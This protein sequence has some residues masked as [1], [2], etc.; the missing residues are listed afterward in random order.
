M[1]G[2]C[3]H[4]RPI[5]AEV[6]K[7]WTVYNHYNSGI[8]SPLCRISDSSSF[9]LGNYETF[10]HPKCI[11]P[12]LFHTTIS[13]TLQLQRLHKPHK[14]SQSS[15]YNLVLLISPV[16][17]L[18]NSFLGDGPEALKKELV[19]L[20]QPRSS[21]EEI[22]MAFSLFL[23]SRDASSENNSEWLK[24]WLKNILINKYTNNP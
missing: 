6:Q 18:P 19:T 16:A 21:Q 17:V 9:F 1:V 5:Q 13:S 15:I 11:L 7:A 3:K 2:K 20:Q 4:A 12:L 14:C 22:Q 10:L 24:D 23:C 8:N